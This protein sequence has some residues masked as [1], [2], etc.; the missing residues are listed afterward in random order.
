MIM[1]EANETIR[2]LV[3]DDQAGIRLSLSG[4]LTRK[5]YRVSVAESGEQALEEVRRNDFRVIFMDIKMPGM[6]GVDAFVKIKEISPRSAVIMM[7][8]YALEDEIRRAVREGAYAVAHKPFDMERILSI[9]EESLHGKTLI[10]VMDGAP[11]SR[12]GVKQA[13]EKKGYKV[14]DVESAEECVR[15]VKER[16]FQIVLLDVKSPEGEMR[17]LKEVRDLRPD[18]AVIVVTA[19][20]AEDLVEDALKKGS[21][22]CL[23]K[24]VEMDRLMETVDRCLEEENR[25]GRAP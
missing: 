14:V 20:S 18:V 8:A 10:L 2:M 9:V 1:K 25:R 6:S 12:E 24:P 7:T 16:R 11:A 22:V 13:L 15:Q 21:F 5:G 3:V 4:I 19:R 17:A 23:S